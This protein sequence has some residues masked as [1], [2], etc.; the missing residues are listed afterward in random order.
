MSKVLVSSSYLTAIANAIRG[1]NGSSNTYK[2]SQMAGAISNIPTGGGYEDALIA[3]SRIEEY[4]NTT[5]SQVAEY[6]FYN[7]NIGK[8]TFTTADTIRA[9][10]FMSARAT[11][12]HLPNA[13]TVQL[14]TFHS[15]SSLVTV[16]IGKIA[17]FPNNI[18]YNCTSLQNVIIRAFIEP[19]AAAT[20]ATTLLGTSN[21]GGYVYVPTSLLS[22][23]QA[24]TNWQTYAK[25]LAFR[26]IEGSIY[27]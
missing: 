7:S 17:S 9:A 25:V 5:A 21:A 2:P 6:R 10:A 3:N 23:F 18:F 8:I 19:T 20:F 13:V 14:N 1:K 27:E 11:E 22:Q 12:I 16:D 26:T 24:S 15:C 4:I